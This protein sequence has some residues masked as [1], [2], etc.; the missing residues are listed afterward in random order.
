M[1]ELVLFRHATKDPSPETR[2]PRLSESGLLG[3]SVG[4]DILTSYDL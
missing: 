3:Q 4:S 2:S 1:P